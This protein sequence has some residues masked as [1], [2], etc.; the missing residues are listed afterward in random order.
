MGDPAIMAVW[1][2]MT[3][4]CQGYDDLQGTLSDLL[5]LQPTISHYLRGC[6]EQGTAARL[7]RI[8]DEVR[9]ALGPAPQGDPTDATH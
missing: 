8:C 5:A 6:H 9:A 7:E 1:D 4:K 2:E 3:L